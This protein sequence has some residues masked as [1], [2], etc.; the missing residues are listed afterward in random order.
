MPHDDSI[1]D[2]YYTQPGLAKALK[3]HERTIL[4]WRRQHERHAQLSRAGEEPL[5]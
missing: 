2:E 4:R 5:V 3:K 1:L